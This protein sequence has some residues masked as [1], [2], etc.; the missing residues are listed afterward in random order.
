[1]AEYTRV[2]RQEHPST[3]PLR[4][5]KMDVSYMYRDDFYMTYSFTLAQEE[6]SPEKVTEALKVAVERATAASPKTIQL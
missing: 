1:M 6:D 3:N 5:G 2:T 4:V